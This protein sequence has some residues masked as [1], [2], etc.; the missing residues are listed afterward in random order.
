MAERLEA[1]LDTKLDRFEIKQDLDMH[2]QRKR[3]P[4]LENNSGSW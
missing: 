3:A 1:K 2:E 4:A